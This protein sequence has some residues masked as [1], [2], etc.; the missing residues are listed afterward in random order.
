LGSLVRVSVALA[1]ARW[2]P[3]IEFM[4][5]Q[6]H[7]PYRVWEHIHR[8]RDSEGATIIEDVVRYRLPFVPLGEIF[9]WCGGS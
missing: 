8:F 3:L 6:L 7:G 5:V 9:R 1:G 2:Q 4:D